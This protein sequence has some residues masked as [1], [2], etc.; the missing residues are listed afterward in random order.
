MQAKD[1]P[2]LLNHVKDLFSVEVAVNAMTKAEPGDDDGEATYKAVTLPYANLSLHGASKS[3]FIQTMCGLV[4]C[5]RPEDLRVEWAA[6]PFSID[7]EAGTASVHLRVPGHP[8]FLEAWDDKIVEPADISNVVSACGIEYMGVQTLVMQ[9]VEP[10]EHEFRA[11]SY[12]M[13][14][15]SLFVSVMLAIYDR[16]EPAELEFAWRKPPTLKQLLSSNVFQAT[17]VS[18]VTTR[19]RIVVA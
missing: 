12:R 4:L 3:L 8:E 11:P 7:K 19:S 2:L 17:A 14:L 13:A 5:G 9:G 10:K 1:F 15:R 18:M 16:G 6:E